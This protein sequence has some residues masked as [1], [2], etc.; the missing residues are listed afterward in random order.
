MGLGVGS[1]ANGKASDSGSSMQG[2]AQVPGRSREP[3]TPPPADGVPHPAPS[4]SP[5]PSPP[6]L[7][8]CTVCGRSFNTKRGLGVHMR[9]AHPVERDQQ[10]AALPARTK[11]RW[12]DEELRLMARDEATFVAAGERFVN[13]ALLRSRPERSL[14]G[15]KGVRRRADYRTL[16][17]QASADLRNARA[18]PVR[19]VPRVPTPRRTPVGPRVREL[20]QRF[21]H[22]DAEPADGGEAGPTPPR[23][24]SPDAGVRSSSS[25]P[26]SAPTTP[27]TLPQA[28]PP[29]HLP[30]PEPRDPNVLQGNVVPFPFFPQH[31]TFLPAIRALTILSQRVDGWQSHQLTSLALEAFSIQDL[32][33]QK[34]YLAVSLS[35]WYHSIFPEPQPSAVDDRPQGPARPTKPPK[36]RP[37]RKLRRM[38]Y[39]RTQKLFRKDMSKCV[40]MILDGDS[41]TEPPTMPPQDA[42]LRYW[43]EL[44]GRQSVALPPR[45]AYPR[46]ADLASVWKPITASEVVRERIAL[47]SAPGPDGVTPKQWSCVPVMIQALF[48]NL[49]LAQGGFPVSLLG[50]RTV[51]IPKKGGKGSPSDF[52]PISVSSVAVRHL[53][54]ILA[55]RLYKLGLSSISQRCF[56]DGC[57]ENVFVLGSLL[58]QVRQDPRRGLHL[59]SLDLAKAYDSVSHAAI[60]HALRSKGLP[61]GL[62]SYVEQLYAASH[63]SFEL[64][65]RRSPPVRV[66]RGVRQGDPL[67]PLLFAYVVDLILGECPVDVSVKLGGEPISSLAYADDVLLFGETQRG[68]TLALAKF[69]AAA[70]KFGLE[71]NV[72]K[73]FTL[74]YVPL[75]H[76]KTF[77][78]QSV[79]PFQLESGVLPQLDASSRWTYLGV[80]FGVGGPLNAEPK[81]EAFLERLTRAPLKPQQRLLALRAFLLPRLF[82][83][84]VLGRCSRRFLKWADIRVRAAV[85]SWLRLPGDVPV[86]FFHAAVRDGGL[87]IPNLS[88]DVPSMME[89]RIK[90]L[91]RSSLPALKVVATSGWADYHRRLRLAALSLPDGTVCNGSRAQR[92][93]YWRKQLASCVDGK[94]LQ[95]ARRVPAST[96]WI[97]AK[98][99]SIPGRDY[100]QHVRTWINALP[101]RIRTSRGRKVRG[102]ASV[103]CRAGCR[104]DE[105]GAHIVQGCHRT[106]GGRIKRH[107]AIAATLS[108]EL[109]KRGYVVA[110]E[111]VFFTAVGQRKPDIVWTRGRNTGILDVQVVSGSGLLDRAAIV[112][113]RKYADI[114]DMENSVRLL[115]RLPAQQR[116]QYDTATISWRGVWSR[117]S[118]EQ[119]KR[120]GLPSGLLTSITTR[121]LQGSHMNFSRFMRM[122][123]TVAKPRTRNRRDQQG[124]RPRPPGV[125]PAGIG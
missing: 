1:S 7:P 48:F 54:K 73:S 27:P 25:S 88:L 29:F 59:A 101:S 109:G 97:S 123:T 22:V 14:E 36:P 96:S 11:M 116:F 24:H 68:L 98:A 120:L 65:G 77:F 21:E 106:H 90:S 118:A 119:L 74:S 5:P 26:V 40:R 53:H 62:C 81:L 60:T 122:T 89:S 37:K 115:H 46:R 117:R 31:D 32:P 10:L 20:M 86:S 103:Q 80:E 121:V 51:F 93:R 35:A 41:F 8:T 43:T 79:R 100:I 13:L 76:E 61:E 4:A 94:E 3:P 50:S 83:S 99:L 64:R 75:G 2:A 125:V 69:E 67:S 44:V 15:V 12:T 58:R 38:E 91:A 19:P 87:G 107:D 72:G 34:L 113:E 16:V 105:T 66:N 56:G 30:E 82:H 112:K 102:S 104:L 17:Q 6:V 70:K 33:R 9:S 47:S 114:P 124:R 42:M 39:A 108:S 55:A 84:L 45:A 49:V 63:T 85:R 18:S 52:R 28:S 23:P 78:I 71:V 111:R 110:R 95:E 92:Q 57:A